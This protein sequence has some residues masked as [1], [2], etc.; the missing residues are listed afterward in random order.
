MWAGR[1]G[2]GREAGSLAGYVPT[3]CA[4]TRDRLAPGGTRAIADRA[5]AISWSRPRAA[6]WYRRAALTLLCPSRSCSSAKRRP[7]ACRHRGAGV[8]EVVHAK[9]RAA[10]PPPGPS[11]SAG[12][13]S[14]AAGA[15]RRRPREEEGVGSRRR[16]RVEVV[17]DRRNDVRR[18]GDHPRASRRLR[19]AHD[20]LAPTQDTARTTRTVAVAT[21]TSLRR[22]SSTSPLRRAHQ[23]PSSTSARST[24]RHGL[25]NHLELLDRRR[26]DL[27][28]PREC[29]ALPR[30][31]H[32]LLSISS[33][34]TAVFMTAFSSA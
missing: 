32:G 25:D 10:R 33:S 23:A 6:C 27:P 7:G 2:R 20:G 28:G 24:V 19:R 3:A 22:S 18:D 15:R 4:G 16:H 17:G 12:A 26:A 1:C 5:A 9:V 8:P 30:M 34:A 29:S 13:S 21:S 31:R 11:A 14:T